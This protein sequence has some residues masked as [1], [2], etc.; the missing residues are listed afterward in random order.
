MLL[1]VLCDMT[2]SIK[3]NVDTSDLLKLAYLLVFLH[4]VVN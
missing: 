4:W 1:G 2:S 3:W